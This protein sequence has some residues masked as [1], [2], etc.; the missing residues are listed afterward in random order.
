MER[1]VDFE[2]ETGPYLQYAHTRCLSILRKA[3][4]TA[5]PIWDSSLVAELKTP[6]EILL[7]KTLGQFPLHLNRSL[8]FSK[9]SQLANYM[10]D[11]TKAFGAFYR[12]R[13]VLTD[14]KNLTQAR[15]CLVEA[16]RR[17]LGRGLSLLGIPLPEK[18]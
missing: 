12:E 6:E 16:T 9:A 18:M 4:A 3:G 14:D 10:I 7:T 11:V 13:K 17:I 15:L 8:H 2:G 1:V 5:A